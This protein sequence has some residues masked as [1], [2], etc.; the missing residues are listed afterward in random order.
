MRRP[1]LLAVAALLS[2]SA[3]LAV[4]ILLFGHFGE[5][6]GRILATTA[7]LAGYGL[8]A[9]PAA[10]LFD[11]ERL[12]ALAAAVAALAAVGASLALAAVW[13][14]GDS[15]PLGKTIGTLTFF[16]VAA[17]QTAALAARRR[18][19]DPRWVRVLFP[20]SVGL[21][22]AAAGAATGA[23]WANAGDAYG[24]VVGAV[25]V[26]DLLA[27]ALQPV[28]ARAQAA[29]APIRLSVLVDSGERVDLTVEAPD[30]A[31]A[32]A[33]AI[34]QLEREGRRVRGLEA[35]DR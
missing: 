28:L 24:R 26:L 10:I 16:L 23:V 3:L 8:L 20:C 15:E 19:R 21:A 6:E 4:G 17:T 18:G 27:V 33:K 2:A 12:R 31:G 34:R 7:L 32:A 35:L 22:L 13:G 11:Q 25:V 14:G 9:V 29:P 5:T 1:L 30:L